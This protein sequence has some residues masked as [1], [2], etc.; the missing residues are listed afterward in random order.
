MYTYEVGKPFPHPQYLP[1]GQELA[2]PMITSSFFDVIFYSLNPASDHR[3]FTRG[4]IRYGLYHRNNV[5]FFIVD[6]E[7]FDFDVSLNIH[8]VADEEVEAWLN[9]DGN[10]ISMYLVDA[11]Q[12]IIHGIRMVSIK[13]QIA[14]QIRNICEAQDAAYESA[15]DVDWAAEQITR[16]LTTQQMKQ[17]IQLHAL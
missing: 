2:R 16:Q 17:R 8:K 4:K 10:L 5:P 11:K 6:F 7:D 9:G 12:N 13:P 3:L 14:S 1:P 15:G